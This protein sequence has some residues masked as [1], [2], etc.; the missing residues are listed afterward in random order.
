MG[1]RRPILGASLV[2]A[3]LLGAAHFS[4]A[5]GDEAFVQATRGSRDA[6][7]LPARRLFGGET[8]ETKETKEPEERESRSDDGFIMP[9]SAAEEKRMLKKEG[10]WKSDFDDLP[11]SEKMSNPFVLITLVTFASPFIY[12]TY[13]LLSATDSS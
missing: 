1:S 3:A 7:M 2:I 9:Q 12:C 13:L 5:P 8:K 11:D 6:R 10:F 4:Y